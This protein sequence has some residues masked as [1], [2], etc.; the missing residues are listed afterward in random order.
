VRG[1]YLVRLN[2]RTCQQRW[3]TLVDSDPTTIVTGSPTVDDGVVYLGT[4]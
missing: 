4:S 1:A 2:A 3:K